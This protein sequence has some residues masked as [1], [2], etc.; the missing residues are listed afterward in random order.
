[1]GNDSLGSVRRAKH[2]PPGALERLS[3]SP[4]KNIPL[5][6]NSDLSY[7]RNTSARRQ[8]GGSRSSRT[9]GWGAMDATASGANGV[10]GRE[11]PR[12]V[13]REQRLS[14]DDTALTASS[15]GFRGE[16]TPAFEGPAKM[17]ADGQVVWSWRPKL[18]S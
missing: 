7:K 14:R 6:R 3:S 17:C 16:R 15:H 1:M 9:A 12:R 4:R 8:R 10:A 18:A 13:L 11:S 5:Y 2:L